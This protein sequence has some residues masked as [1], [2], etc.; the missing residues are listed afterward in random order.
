M[1][2][3]KLKS[4]LTEANMLENHLSGSGLTP[5]VKKQHPKG[6]SWWWERTLNYHRAGMDSEM[7]R[8]RQKNSNSLPCKGRCLWPAMAGH[9]LLL[10]LSPALVS[11]TSLSQPAWLPAAPPLR[12]PLLLISTQHLLQTPFVSPSSLFSVF[13]A[14][15][16]TFSSPWVFPST[17]S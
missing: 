5:K 10:K 9:P 15:T 7:T 17:E 11:Q 4:E 16:Y 8:A 1:G 14:N 2:E 3:A 13:S 6:E 12:S